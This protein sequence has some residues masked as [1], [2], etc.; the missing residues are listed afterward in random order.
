MTDVL[1]RNLRQHARVDRAARQH[2]FYFLSL[3]QT[4]DF[5]PLRRLPAGNLL[6]L[7]GANA[8]R[9]RR[10]AVF[11][12][13]HPAHPQRYR[14]E[15]GAHADNFTGKVF[16]LMNAAGGVNEHVAMTEFSMWKNRDGAKRRAATDPTE[17]HAHL[18]LANIEFQIARKPSVALFRRQRNNT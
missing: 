2:I 15:V 12:L 7:I 11:F 3:R 6:L 5:H 14:I 10:H 18:E 9:A 1:R 8:Q 17:K 4:S 16:G 13:Q